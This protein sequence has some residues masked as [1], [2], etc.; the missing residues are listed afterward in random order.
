MAETAT[1]RDFSE[2]IKVLLLNWSEVCSFSFAKY[3]TFV[4]G[5]AFELSVKY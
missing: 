2:E 1:Y 4:T 3:E 5:F